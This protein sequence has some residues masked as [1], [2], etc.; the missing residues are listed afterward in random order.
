MARVIITLATSTQM[1]YRGSGHR[2]IIIYVLLV[3][4]VLMNVEGKKITHLDIN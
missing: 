1:I 4:D 3:Y 2:S